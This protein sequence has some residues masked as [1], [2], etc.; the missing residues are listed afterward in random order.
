MTLAHNVTQFKCR[1]CGESLQ[2]D[3]TD[4]SSFISKS[5]HEDFFGMKLTTYRVAHESQNDRHINVVIADHA[6]LFR[7]H[8]DAYSEPL[9]EKGPS[10]ERNY[11]VYHE[12][13]PPLEKTKNV[14]LAFLISRTD[15][16]VVDVV[17]PKALNVSETATIIV[18]RVEEAQRVYNAVPQPMETKVADM[19]IH[20]WAS[21][22]RILAVSFSNGSLLNTIDSIASH[23]VTEQED[24]IVP[25]RRL[26]NVIF[27]ILENTPDLSPTMLTRIMNEDMLFTK[28]H[29]PYEDRI[30]SI[31]ERTSQRYPI[32]GEILGPLL[33]GFTTLVEALEGDFSSRYE[34]IFELIDFVN[35]RRILG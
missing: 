33:R 7:G 8:R 11:W 9:T 13:S 18:D 20:A 2:F 1:V 16:W 12:D 24:S 6:G 35:R 23:I 4:P 14:V 5:G 22:D 21:D 10:I 26:L 15:R 27:R 32:A 28:F 29:T 19:N 34:E 31:V 30:P 17:S 3:M 25:R